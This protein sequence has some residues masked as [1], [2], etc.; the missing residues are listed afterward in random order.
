MSQVITK[1]VRLSRRLFLK[2]AQ[3]IVGLPPLVSMF[4]ATGTAYAATTK[5]C[6]EVPAARS[7][8]APLR[9]VVQRERYRGAILDSQ[10][11]RRGL[12][13]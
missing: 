10:P 3:V 11:N 9:P 8:N 6:R 2:G 5:T 4:N 12:R 7:P 13:H 1:R